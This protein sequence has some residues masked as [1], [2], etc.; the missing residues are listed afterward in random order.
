MHTTSGQWG[1]GL[2][3]G[4]LTALQWGGLPI[5]LKVV[6]DGMDPYTVTW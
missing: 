3:L 1:F 5:A 6:L 2:L 4:F